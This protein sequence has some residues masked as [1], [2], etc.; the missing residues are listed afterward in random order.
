MDEF[1][2][3]IKNYDELKM[4]M[5]L[6]DQQ[7]NT[8]QHLRR[9]ERLIRNVSSKQ[10]CS[11]DFKFCIEIMQNNHKKTVGGGFGKKEI[12]IGNRNS[13]I[14]KLLNSKSSSIEKI[15]P[16]I[17]VPN[18]FIRGNINLTNSFD[19]I[20]KGQFMD[21]PISED[22]K[23]RNYALDLKILDTNVVFEIWD[24]INYLKNKKRLHH[25]VAIFIDGSP[26]QFK[27]SKSLWKIESI[28]KLF[29]KSKLISKRLLSQVLRHK[30]T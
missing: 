5:N 18:T 30:A 17:L 9:Y 16:I 26:Y 23:A 15:K 2:G 13:V 25:V 8:I 21:I 29:K 28:A 11:K 20:K 7:I 14:S 3:L 27:N 22:I 10:K 6:T 1:K 24:D 19:F 12:V 4:E